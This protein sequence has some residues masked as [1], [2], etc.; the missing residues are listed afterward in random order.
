M[1]I[2][3]RVIAVSIIIAMLFGVGAVRA[4]ENLDHGKTP[5]QLYASDCAICHKSPRG[6]SQAGGLFGLQNFLRTHYAASIQSAAAVAVYLQEVDRQ[7]PPSRKHITRR[8]PKNPRAPKARPTPAGQDKADDTK[9]SARPDDSKGK[10]GPDADK[11][12]ETGPAD[13]ASSEARA[14]APD[15]DSKPAAASSPESGSGTKSGGAKPGA[16][17]DGAADSVPD[18]IKP[19]KSD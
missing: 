9:K 7:A 4:Q 11:P 6:L 19:E 15:H 10:T 13:A 5:A 12:A 14:A 8:P 17:Q 1:G 3:G 18:I 16:P 2:T